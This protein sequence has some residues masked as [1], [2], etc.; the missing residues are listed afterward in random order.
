MVGPRSD[1]GPPA[2]VMAQ[3]LAVSYRQK[4]LMAR[5]RLL[6]SALVAAVLLAVPAG[7]SADHLDRLGFRFVSP[8]FVA[9]ESDHRATITVTRRNILNGAQVRYVTVHDSAT[10]YQDY[11]PVKG[12]LDFA[13]GQATATF[14]IPVVDHH[15]PGATRTV[16]LGLFGASPIGLARPSNAEL[17]IIE[18]DALSM[19]RNPLNPLGLAAAPAGHDPLTG[20]R[21]SSTCS[22][23]RPAQQIQ[24]LAWSPSRARPGCCGSSPASPRS[25]GSA[26]GRSDIASH[27]SRF[28]ARANAAAATVPEMA[29]YWLNNGHCGH[30]SDSPARAALY[31]RWTSTSRRG[32]RATGRSCSWTWTR[33]SPPAASAHTVS[34]SGWPSSVTPIDVLSQQ[35]RL[36]IYLDAGA[37]DGLSASRTAWLLNHA[38]V[39]KIQGFFL[40]STHYDWTS[41]EIRYGWAISRHTGGKH[42]VVSTSVNGRGPLKPPHPV[43]RATRCCATR[44]AAASAPSRRSTRATGSSTPSPGSGSPAA[45][46]TARRTRPRPTLSGRRWPRPRSATRTSGSAGAGDPPTD[47]SAPPQRLSSG[48]SSP[49]P[50]TCSPSSRQASCARC[51]S[52]GGIAERE[53]EPP[54]AA[55]GHR[56]LDR[57]AVRPS[58]GSG[59]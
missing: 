11:T 50:T 48:R 7:A 22:G 2:N 33:S 16:K 42:F 15:M 41:R 49:D 46:A 59:A 4:P 20:A 51:D 32:S 31:H 43:R 57:R 34:R 55:G 35:P 52:V 17:T 53:L 44:P 56:A 5:I 19:L 37:A 38:G 39:S 8:V 3:G 12:R 45:R 14:S 54:L 28:L 10:P 1:H 18:D 29:T 24:A 26:T 13:P 6:L 47:R 30:Y 58:S 27:V 25:R 36:V 9:H 21:R 23:T 40:N